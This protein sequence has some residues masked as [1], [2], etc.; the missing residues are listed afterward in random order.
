MRK[1]FV[2]ACAWA[3]AACRQA[4]PPQAAAPP[5]RLDGVVEIP[6]ESPKMRQIR[7]AEVRV[8]RLPRDEFTAPA[9]IEFNPN[10]VSRVVLPAPGRVAEV[11]V[12]FGDA[13]EKGAPL[14]ALESPAADEA[15]AEYLR[16]DLTLTAARAEL[17][18]AQ[19]DYDRV[20]DLFRGDAIAKKEVL[21]AETTLRQA[22]A[23]VAQAETSR[24]H[25][26]ARL[27]LLGL[28][29]GESRP[30]IT[31]RA[32]LSGK[33]IEFNVVAGEYRTD[34]SQPVMTLADLSTVWVAADVPETSIRLVQLGE[35]FE[36]RLNAYPGEVFQSRVTRIADSV[37][38][39]NR[40]L[41]VWAELDNRAGRFR[42]E[43]FGTVRHL[44]SER[45]V[46]VAPVGALVQMEGREAVFVEEAPG[47]FRAVAVK[48]GKRIGDWVPIVEGLRPG[49]R[50]VVDGGM[51]LRGN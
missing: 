22:T 43:M 2:L 11:F 9:K 25:A 10:R 47:R 27:E 49:A 3:L 35:R 50:I 16:A 7:V 31:V 23:A 41:K 20:L 21:A 34:T 15:A 42:P 38:P 19:Q 17:T 33:V 51:L 14:L 18:K 26:L 37:D 48:A 1:L 8:E 32:P 40:T 12:A 24:Q 30:R 4:P 46:P 28:K 39:V 13:V 44:E 6:P 5:A 45:D 29:P 36:V